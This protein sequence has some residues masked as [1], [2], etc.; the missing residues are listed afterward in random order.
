M[1]P[2]DK[3]LLQG[4]CKTLQCHFQIWISRNREQIAKKIFLDLNEN[5]SANQAENLMRRLV[6][7]RF[8]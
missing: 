4:F 1:L 6:V 8:V 2:E 5:P 7:P 3:I